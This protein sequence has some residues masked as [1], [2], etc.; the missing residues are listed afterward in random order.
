MWGTPLGDVLLIDEQTLARPT[1]RNFNK[2]R[3][4][5]LTGSPSCG[6]FNTILAACTTPDNLRRLSTDGLAA[7]CIEL[8]QIYSESNQLLD[9]EY[10][11]RCLQILA[12][13]LQI[14]LMEFMNP[15]WLGA[16]V[17]HSGNYY[18]T[19][20]VADHVG[21]VL[22]QRIIT[23][24]PFWPEKD[25]VFD[26]GW[27][28]IPEHPGTLSCLPDSGGF[29]WDNAAFLMAA[30]F[31]NGD[32]LQS[33]LQNTWIPGLGT[34]LFLCWQHTLVRDD[35]QA[36]SVMLMGLTLRFVSGAMDGERGLLD[37]MFGLAS[38]RVNWVPPPS[39]DFIAAGPGDMR[40][41]L[42]AQVDNMCALKGQFNYFPVGHA[43]AVLQFLRHGPTSSVPD[44][45]MAL[46]MTTLRRCWKELVEPEQ[47]RE[48]V[49]LILG[50]AVEALRYVLLEAYRILAEWV[51]VDGKAS[52]IA[53]R[54]VLPGPRITRSPD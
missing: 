52:A 5:L 1:Y 43:A 16:C 18:Y 53:P 27:H 24:Q 49:H 4:M 7:R 36:F 2:A 32:K 11:L 12:L 48:G 40:A 38:H 34:V 15:N 26:L 29:T 22:Q 14:N 37:L 21:R 25:L 45:V 3:D 41:L 28:S 17:P 9:Y 10:G 19:L 30:L 44:A 51:Q 31:K 54:H 8:L 39:P 47:D 50:M 46:T 42:E 6:E 33:S 23:H 13:S 20:G 35:C